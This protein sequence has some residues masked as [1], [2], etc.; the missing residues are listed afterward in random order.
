[1]FFVRQGASNPLAVFLPN[2]PP[3]TV[4]G[5][6]TIDVKDNGPHI[7]NVAASPISHI[8]M[9]S[10][11]VVNGRAWVDWWIQA[12]VLTKLHTQKNGSAKKELVRTTFQTQF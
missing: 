5:K 11:I 9:M 1:M 12:T 10:T 3:R 7:A 6:P 4:R 2:I 8:H